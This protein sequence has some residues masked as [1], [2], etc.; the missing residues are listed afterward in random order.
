M[1]H[2][3]RPTLI[4]DTPFGQMRTIFRRADQ[5][6]FRDLSDAVWNEKEK[7]HVAGEPITVNRVQYRANF[8]FERIDTVWKQTYGTIDRVGSYKAFDY[9]SAALKKVSTTLAQIVAELEETQ[10]DTLQAAQ[11][12]SLTDEYERAV[13]KVIGLRHEV[14]K[15][16]TEARRLREK[17]TEAQAE[18]GMLDS[19]E[20]E[21]RYLTRD[22]IESIADLV[23]SKKFADFLRGE[24][25]PGNGRCLEVCLSV[26]QAREVDAVWEQLESERSQDSE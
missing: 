14:E 21:K 2:Y 7:A 3:D 25:N 6:M 22:E 5:I 23:S 4:I 19:A 12:A 10:A 8:T 18:A 24:H 1:S 17:L 16:E 9:S 20:M 11:I 13:G 26:G 15:A